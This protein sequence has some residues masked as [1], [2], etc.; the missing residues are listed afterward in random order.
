M[1]VERNACSETDQPAFPNGTHRWFQGNGLNDQPPPVDYVYLFQQYCNML[2]TLYHQE[3]FH[4]DFFVIPILVF[5]CLHQ[6]PNQDSVRCVNIKT[7][8]KLFDVCRLL[9]LLRVILLV[10]LAFKAPTTP[11]KDIKRDTR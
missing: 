11:N 7:G 8:C 3:L 1:D 5:F 9:F 10:N 6:V 2:A 4:H